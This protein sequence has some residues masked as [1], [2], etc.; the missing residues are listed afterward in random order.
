MMTQI[1]LKLNNNDLRKKLYTGQWQF[2]AESGARW[3]FYFRLGRLIWCEG[4]SY[5]KEPLSRYI[6]YYCPEIKNKLPKLKQDFTED[7]SQILLKLYQRQFI[8]Q[9]T[10]STIISGMAKEFIFDI[11]QWN[12]T[13]EISESQPSKQI[14]SSFPPLT[15]IDSILE[16]VK[17]SWQ[18]WQK[19]GLA[20]YSPN[21]YPIIQNNRK[22]DQELISIIDGFH[23]LREIAWKTSQNLLDLTNSLIPFINAGA[24]V[25]SRSPKTKLTK[26]SGLVQSVPEKTVTL[27][28][29]VKQFRGSSYLQESQSYQDSIDQ[30]RQLLQQ[31]TTV[32]L[33]INCSS[34]KMTISLINQ[35]WDRLTSVFE[36]WAEVKQI[37]DFKDGQIILQLIPNNEVKQATELSSPITT[38]DNDIR[39]EQRV[40]LNV[41]STQFRGNFSLQESPNYQVSVQ[42]AQALIQQGNI[43]ELIV[44]FQSQKSIDTTLANQFL[45]RLIEQ[46]QDSAEVEQIS[47]LENNQI[48][49]RLFPKKI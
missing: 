35:L 24:I 42:K 20:N 49:L 17:T 9:E 31:G 38:T 34:Q 10:L 33:I 22:I 21:L 27:E 41:I 12:Q 16:A 37:S 8:N 11:I 15:E 26:K 48:I 36:S 32:K 47:E 14:P 40:S 25:L 30:A 18:E 5:W 7:K 3:L 29:I 44:N 4:P 23:T 13:E 6:A 46:F 2:E 39:G 1:Y 43:V 28:F 45:N 19:A